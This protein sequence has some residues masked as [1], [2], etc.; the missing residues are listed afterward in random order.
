VSILLSMQKNKKKYLLGV[1]A[2]TGIHG[3]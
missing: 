2:Y 3:N 1:I